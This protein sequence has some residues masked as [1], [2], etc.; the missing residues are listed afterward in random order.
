[1]GASPSPNDEASPS[2]LRLPSIFSSKLGNTKEKTGNGGKNDVRDAAGMDLS[3]FRSALPK[4][5]KAESFTLPPKP[6]G[7][8]PAGVTDGRGV[9]QKRSQ[10]FGNF[11]VAAADVAASRQ[12]IAP[13]SM[14]GGAGGSDGGGVPSGDGFLRRSSPVGLGGVNEGSG[15]D[16]VHGNATNQRGMPPRR[17]GTFPPDQQG[18][19]ASSMPGG[20]GMVPR[21]PAPGTSSNNAA[22]TEGNP[23]APR[24]E[25]AHASLPALAL[26][27]Q[28]RG[29]H[30]AHAG[31]SRP[32]HAASS[33]NGSAS[34]NADC[35]TPTPAANN[36]G[37]RASASCGMTSASQAPAPAPLVIPPRQAPP[38]LRVEGGEGSHQHAPGGE[39][40]LRWWEEP[41]SP[42]SAAVMSSLAEGE[43]GG[44]GGG[45]DG[46]GNQ[47]QGRKG[48][49]ARRGPSNLGRPNEGDATAL[50]HQPPQQ[51][52]QPQGD[53]PGDL[54]RRRGSVGGGTH[55]IALLGGG[56]DGGGGAGSGIKQRGEPTVNCSVEAS[57][58]PRVAPTGAEAAGGFGAG[59]ADAGSKLLR[60]GLVENPRGNAPFSSMA[61]AGSDPAGGRFADGSQQDMPPPPHAQGAW[62]GSS[63]RR[64]PVQIERSLSG[65]SNPGSMSAK[66]GEGSGGAHAEAGEGEPA[67]AKKVEAGQVCSE[68]VLAKLLPV[69]DAR[70]RDGGGKGGGAR[71]KPEGRSNNS[72]GVGSSDNV[73][74][75]LY[76]HARAKEDALTGPPVGWLAPNQLAC[77]FAWVQ[78]P[79]DL[80]SLS[81]VCKAWRDVTATS[82][83]LWEALTRA[84]WPKTGAT[85][86]PAT[87]T[88]PIQAGANAGTS[89][90]GRAGNRS[91][92]KVEPCAWKRHYVEM[93]RRSAASKAAKV[94]AK[95][96]HV[97][98]L[99][100]RMKLDASQVG[101]SA[102]KAYAEYDF[103]PGSLEAVWKRL[104]PEF[105]VRVNG[106]S[107]WHAVKPGKGSQ[108]VYASASTL[109]LTVDVMGSD[110][111]LGQLTSVTVM[112]RCP[113]IDRSFYVVDM[114]HV[115]IS[116]R[117]G[118]RRK[119]RGA[120]W[121]AP[122][123]WDPAG[124]RPCATL[125]EVRLRSTSAW[126]RRVGPPCCWAR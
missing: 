38:A 125:R 73:F 51:Q 19:S 96:A 49:A 98:Q 15:A 78:D 4:P 50:A 105:S 23:Q 71:A 101:A 112:A 26:L 27:K 74:S 14:P 24:A 108:Q 35:G 124:G 42:M 117:R 123:S 115:M 37:D 99:R 20:S 30:A 40:S 1:M 3:S 106:G 90:G 39:S 9:G 114:M 6:P 102:S 69:A 46:S 59:R 28:H 12:L 16:V 120:C 31:G 88:A 44:G 55:S 21:P 10:S 34:G 8:A 62:R 11:D 48:G 104:A 54:G 93:H 72:S 68:L 52:H 29:S 70:G 66:G 94:V 110:V 18:Y 87:A 92:R 67:L 58:L 119:C 81:S 95:M 103:A 57:A 36:S 97:G 22:P 109:H 107:T 65:R 63:G 83:V 17:Q 89:T 33:N 7:P 126:P 79:A 85:P 41:L 25:P 82:D 84:R 60:K 118:G 45:R 53:R 100:K 56:G 64:A 80:A 61:G 91:A 75:R 5:K 122:R 116:E 121:R 43:E 111:T 77:V 32:P 2:Q 113:A 86:L 47:S 76:N 13:S